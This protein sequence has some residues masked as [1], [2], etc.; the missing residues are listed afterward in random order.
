MAYVQ[1]PFVPD[2]KPCIVIPAHSDNVRPGDN[3]PRVS[4]VHTPEER[5][6]EIEVTPFYFA[7]RIYDANG[8][9]RRASTHFYTSGGLGTLGN[10]D[11]YQMVPEQYGAIANGVT[12]GR[13]YPT[14][15]S[16]SI[17]LN[18]QSRSIEVE[19]FAHSID[20]TMPHGSPQWLTTV[21]W[22][23]YGYYDHG[24][25]IDRAHIIGHYEVS[26]VRTDPGML[27]I[28]DIVED[29]MRLHKRIEAIQHDI[30]ILELKHVLQQSWMEL[31]QDKTEN[32]DLVAALQQGALS[33]HQGRTPGGTGPWTQGTDHE[34]IEK[35]LTAVEDS[36]H[37][38]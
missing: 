19:G 10:G 12:S 38:G 7:R 27:N 22:C 25:P 3:Q 31:H 5:A 26:N 15:T 13:N 23:L 34:E 30:E 33:Q 8:I 35:R 36:A 6:D 16:P 4:I 20:R 29:T 37:T 14:D 9:Q 11:L 2:I 28:D 32:Q 21:E 18:L 24:I 1:Q 17:S